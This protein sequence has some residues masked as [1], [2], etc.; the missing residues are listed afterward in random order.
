MAQNS[1]PPAAEQFENFDQQTQNDLKHDAWS[2]AAEE[3]AAEHP[4][5]YDRLDR[6]DAWDGMELEV[7]EDENGRK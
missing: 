6:H 5:L 7:Y 3:F 2:Q 4:D 1:A